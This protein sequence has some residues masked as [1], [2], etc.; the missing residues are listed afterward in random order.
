MFP[1]LSGITIP[2]N[3]SFVAA[4]NTLLRKKLKGVL[5]LLSK[6]PLSSSFP[7]QPG[8]KTAAD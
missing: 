2:V 8:A 5:L 6:T 1:G 4:G 7:F 3:G